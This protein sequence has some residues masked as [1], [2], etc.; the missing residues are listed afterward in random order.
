MKC[1]MD[2]KRAASIDWASVNYKTFDNDL[3][4]FWAVQ[5]LRK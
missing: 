5:S 1:T 3:T 4:K 2:A